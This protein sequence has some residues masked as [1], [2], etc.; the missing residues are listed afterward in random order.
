MFETSQD[1]HKSEIKC[2][3]KFRPLPLKMFLNPYPPP[4]VFGQANVCLTVFQF[5]KK[6]I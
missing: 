3:R 6:E 1:F 5:L 4:K 2:S